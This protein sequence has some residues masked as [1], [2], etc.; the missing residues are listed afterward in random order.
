MKLHHHRVGAVLVALL[1]EAV[2]LTAAPGTFTV[3]TYN[4]E[5]YLDAPGGARKAK[6]PEARAK[7]GEFIRQMNPDVIALQEMGAV[8]ALQE[9]RA[10]L[11]N[12][13]T[14]FPHWEHVTGHD[15]NIHLAVLSKFPI[16]AR[17][18]H[19][20]AGF[21]LD[22]RRFQV[23]RGFAEVEIQ[24]APGYAFTLITAHLKSKRPV[25]EA[26][27]ADLREREAALLREII[28]ARLKARPEIN[29]IV[30]G[31]FNDLRDSKPV[32]TIIGRG[33]TAL[34][35]TRPAEPGGAAPL[36][37]VSGYAPR[38]VTWT[39]HYGKEDSYTRVDYLLLSR[40]MARE[41]IPAQS[42][43]FTAPDWGRASDHR[44]LI[45]TFTL[46]DQ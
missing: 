15:T 40:G 27:Q 25:P 36:K 46:G 39:Y 44:P 42:R 45:A 2:V 17:R 7:V 37:P 22:G 30:A 14:D 28:D 3:A 35:D 26:D 9:L 1:L 23:S 41:W 20:N 12:A 13:G 21:V 29:L 33:K 5:N 11:K 8:S 18:P 10:G 32:R 43:V 24:P 16:V 31:D 38:E 6:P 34:V 19:T 4:L